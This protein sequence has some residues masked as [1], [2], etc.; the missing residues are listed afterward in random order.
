MYIIHRPSKIMQPPTLLQ[1]ALQLTK[2][3]IEHQPAL[4]RRSHA[5]AAHTAQ[6]LPLHR[7]APRNIITPCANENEVLGA[8]LGVW[9]LMLLL[10]LFGSCGD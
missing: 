4:T 6:A 1:L 10:M 8:V 5:P 2:N 3:I 9:V 7:R